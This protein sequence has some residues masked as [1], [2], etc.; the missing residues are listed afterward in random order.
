[1]PTFLNIYKILSLYSILKPPKTGNCSITKE[2]PTL[3]LVTLA[4]LQS[5][6]HNSDTSVNISNLIKEKLQR[7][8][9]HE[10]WDFETVS[11][12]DYSVPEV[13]S[14]VMYCLTADLSKQICN[15]VKC[16][17]CKDAL[18]RSDANGII[19]PEALLSN[20][21]QRDGLVH[22]NTRLYHF[23]V[24]L[25]KSFQSH[26][27]SPHVFDNILDDVLNYRSLSFPCPDHAH[28]ILYQII[29]YFVTKRMQQYCTR[30]NAE[31][32]KNNQTSKKHSK[33]HTT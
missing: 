7:I 12:H 24:F 15:T 16:L 23:L 17:K 9:Q 6:Y 29:K 31:Q 5:I 11:E 13:A 18:L 19:L 33:F 14:C 3:P 2:N 10:E 32:K 27:D 22:P 30:I 25:E 26:C 20:W 1:M 28:D 8:V 4:D 21:Q